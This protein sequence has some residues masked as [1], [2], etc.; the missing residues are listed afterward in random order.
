MLITVTLNPSLDRTLSIARWEPGG[1]I[2]ARL[3]DRVPAGKGI[4]VAV[5]LSHFTSGVAALGFVGE[6]EQLTFARHLE[7]AGVS[8]CLTPVAGI[9]RENISVID[10]SL[11]RETHLREGGFTVSEAEF[12][13]FCHTLEIHLH[14]AMTRKDGDPSGESFYVLFCGSIPPGIRTEDFLQLLDIC[15]KHD[16]IT[17]V[18]T[19]GP[20]LRAAVDAGV[21]SIKP[22]RTE[23]AEL[24]GMSDSGKGSPIPMMRE[25]LPSV[26]LILLTMGENGAYCA[27][28]DE[29]IYA[30]CRLQK[31][32]VVN[33]VG[34]GDAFLAGFFGSLVTGE[35]RSE[36]L[37]WAVAA[38][39][40]CARIS[41]ATGYTRAQI[42][43]AYQRTE[44]RES[45]GNGD[46]LGP[47]NNPSEPEAPP[48]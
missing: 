29:T 3:L 19:H 31:K 8:E 45:P 34:S 37:R 47:E 1:A 36:A 43:E 2:K 44:L 17:V 39:A 9:T 11:G 42:E 28:A 16:A 7:A 48:D 6:A 18:D 15:K 4:N 38:G 10:E 23:I 26:P 22:N 46:A 27:S 41:T 20:E 24:R 33:T 12:E 32:E 25:L 40:A 14:K 35:S 5:G 30:V 13:T 21:Y